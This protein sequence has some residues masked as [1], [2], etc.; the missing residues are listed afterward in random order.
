MVCPYRFYS[1]SPP[2]MDVAVQSFHRQVLARIVNAFHTHTQGNVVANRA[3]RRVVSHKAMLDNAQE[4]TDTLMA[5]YGRYARLMN[6]PQMLANPET[7]QTEDTLEGF[8]IIRQIRIDIATL[9]KQPTDFQL[10]LIWFIVELMAP[11]IFGQAWTTDR[12]RIKKQM[13]WVEDRDGIGG[14]LTGRKEGKSTGIAMGC[15]IVLLNLRAIPVALFSRTKDQSCIILGMAKELLA[16]HPRINNFKM[17]TS[18][19]IIK[20]IASDSDIREMRAWTGTADVRCVCGGESSS[21]HCMVRRDAE[22]S[23]SRRLRCCS[24]SCCSSRCIRS[25][26]CLCVSSLLLSS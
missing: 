13:G 4:W 23:A 9:P 1:I 11:R 12:A 18:S 19:N 22:R 7:A 6:V 2:T 5:R 21:L 8:E 15:S 17:T 14:V 24:C 25:L 10:K 16:G 3:Y 26:R 20:L